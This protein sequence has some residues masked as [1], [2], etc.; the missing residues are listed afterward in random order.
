MY[1]IT[2]L[3]NPGLKYRNSRHNTGFKAIDLLAEKYR[4]RFS[5]KAF[6]GVVAEGVI[7]GE[8]VILLKPHTFMN[9]SGLSVSEAKRFYKLP[10]ERL[11][12]IYDD[13][14]LSPGF[15]RIRAFGSAG[16]HNGMRSVISECGT[17]QFPRI[18]IGVGKNPPEIDLADYVLGKPDKQDA[19]TILEACG[20][21]VSAVEEILE[22]SVDLAMSRF[23]GR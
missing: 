11:I 1:L 16:S 22:H 8:K 3:G 12:V 13:I 4:L 5:K 21:A 18:R 2:G 9:R 14:D 6:Q 20:K 19:K 7:C 23:N 15:I 17:E 10:D